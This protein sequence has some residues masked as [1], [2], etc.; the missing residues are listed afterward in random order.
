MADEHNN[1]L[2]SAVVDLLTEADNPVRRE[3]AAYVARMRDKLKLPYRTIGRQLNVSRQR[4]GQLYQLHKLLQDIG[5]AEIDDLDPKDYT[6][7]LQPDQAVQSITE[8]MNNK[9][10]SGEFKVWPQGAYRGPYPEYA[11]NAA[12]SMT[13]SGLLAD[14]LE[15]NSKLLDELD[16]TARGLGYTMEHGSRSS[17][18]FYP[19]AESLS[20]PAAE[21]TAAGPIKLADLENIAL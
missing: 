13:L 2:I 1:W 7:S 5:E 15:E 19:D 6:G 20:E 16:L 11:Q 3:R 21:V 17:I 14:H 18:H 9:G 8:F 4:A 12:F 10:L